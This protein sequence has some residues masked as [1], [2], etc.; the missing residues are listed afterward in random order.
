[1]AA[2][3]V[4]VA[5]T[6]LVITPRDL[7]MLASLNAARFLTVEALEWLHFPTWCDRYA[8]WQVKAARGTTRHY[9]PSAQLYSRLRRMEAA[10]LVRRIYRPIALAVSVQK[11]DAD[12]WLL[13]E[14]GA[15]LLA[16]YGGIERDQIDAPAL[17]LRST[18]T[19]QHSAEV[20]RVYA[21]LRS[22]IE[23]KPAIAMSDWRSEHETAKDFDRVQVWLPQADCSGRC[24]VRGIQ[25]DGVFYIDHQRGRTLFFLEVER[26]QPLAKWREKIYAY[27]AYRLTDVFPARYGLTTFT[28]L[29]LAE[30]EHQQQRRLQATAEALM[31]LYPDVEQRQRAQTRY[32]VSHL[33]RAHPTIIGTGWLKLTEVAMGA[34]RGV[35]MATTEHVLLA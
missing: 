8:K 20:G 14:H 12:L 6:R 19:L 24:D 18:Y 27:E 34:G 23:T 11:R 13:A 2:T 31:L 30:D 33:G 3:H 35:R 28:L 32:F 25:P 26:D 17:R 21:A 29:G 4:P 15:D 16:A 9:M 10:K 5:P 1:M 7:Q 22:K